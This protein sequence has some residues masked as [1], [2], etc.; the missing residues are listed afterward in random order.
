MVYS[1][2]VVVW[3]IIGEKKRGT[4]DKKADV[5]LNVSWEAATK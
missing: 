1:I 5:V 2:S 3:D 4:G